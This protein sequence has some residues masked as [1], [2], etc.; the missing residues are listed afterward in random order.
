MLKPHRMST[1]NMQLAA[2]PIAGHVHQ[3]ARTA[4]AAIPKTSGGAS[5]VP[6][7]L[8]IASA[9]V[10]EMAEMFQFRERS[11]SQNAEKKNTYELQ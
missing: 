10:M 8:P 5:R 2:T 11:Q 3:C 9:S 6:L 4:S 7:R 1:T